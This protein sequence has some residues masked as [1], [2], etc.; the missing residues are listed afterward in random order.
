MDIKKL[1][2]CNHLQY[3]NMILCYLDKAC[4]MNMVSKLV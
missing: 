3:I 4:I 1:Y 2:K